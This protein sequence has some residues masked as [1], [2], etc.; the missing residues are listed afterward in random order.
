[1]LLYMVKFC[2]IVRMPSCDYIHSNANLGKR[3]HVIWA[4]KTF[5]FI[6]IPVIIFLKT[7]NKPVIILGCKN[8]NLSLPGR[9]AVIR[10]KTYNNYGK[11]VMVGITV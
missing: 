11:T 2:D 1:M 7:C 8:R 9:N 6:A 10:P 5:N 4:P 3:K